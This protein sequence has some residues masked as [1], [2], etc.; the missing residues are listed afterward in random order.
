M[1]SVTI[2]ERR[3]W[4]T[5][6]LR[7]DHVGS[8]GFAALLGLAYTF[9]LVV[10]LVPVKVDA[11]HSWNGQPMIVGD[12][13][14]F[15]ASCA[16]DLLAGIHIPNDLAR[17]GRLLPILTALLASILPFSF[18]ALIYYIPTVVG[19]LIVAPLMVL[20]RVLGLTRVGFVA[21]LLAS[22]A[23]SYYNRT[24][25]GYFDTDMLTVV[26]AMSLLAVVIAAFVRRSAPCLPLI[27]LVIWLFTAA[28]PQ[29]YVL[30]LVLF[31][32][33]GV[34]GWLFDRRDDF[35]L[36]VMLYMMLGLIA[37]PYALSPV[38]AIGLY[39]TPRLVGPFSS[40]NLRWLLA[41]TSL[42]F[43]AFLVL[44]EPLILEPFRL[45]LLRSGATSGS[46]L[47]FLHVIGSVGENSAVT[48][49]TFSQRVSGPVVALAAAAA[50]YALLCWRH[51][52]LVLSLPLAAI[53]ASAF[54]GG[55]RFSIWAVPPAALGLAFV[56][57]LGVQPLR[58]A[59]LRHGAAALATGLAL[60]PHLTHVSATHEIPPFNNR[61]AR[62]LDR[63]G[64]IVSREDF[65]VAW[66]DFGYPI[67]YY[68][69]LKPVVDGGRNQ[70]DVTFPVSLVLT[71][72]D[73]R[74]AR[75]MARLTAAYSEVDRSS[76]ESIMEGEGYRDPGEFL[77]S[78]AA[79]SP[80]GDSFT[81]S[82]YPRGG[83][84]GNA[85]AGNAR[86]GGRPP[87]AGDIY[88]ILPYKMLP[89]FP[90]ISRFSNIDLT[91]GRPKPEIQY[92][93][94]RVLRTE[95]DSMVLEDG[96]RIDL[97]GGAIRHGRSSLRLKAVIRA[98]KEPATGR[99]SGKK[100][101]EYPDPA[102]S[103]TLVLMDEYRA[104][105]LV[106]D[107]ALHSQFVQLFVFE[108]YDDRYLEPVIL[109]PTMKVYRFRK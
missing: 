53:G 66:W 100:I 22:V 102:G 19:S 17:G 96:A 74:S 2:R 89:L 14:Y 43:V 48:L 11:L 20:G 92:D 12:D 40:R 97:K 1:T 38:L 84:P 45:F 107:A 37:L 36:R 90:A 35:H 98:Q 65:A 81:G 95:G 103:L 42:G 91:T 76:L 51:R 15:Y 50:G 71:T 46:T 105:L 30:L 16:R 64:A 56:I 104:A 57:M 63:L 61:E 86:T 13:G 47:R 83:R 93:L 25:A 106:D 59:A 58:L 67:R 72:T 41:A 62:V 21:A 49:T 70:G 77:R 75:K 32:V 26:L 55:A 24:M 52:V 94:T 31:L 78:L 8:M 3:L 44:G 109:D 108:E 4:D 60:Y 69:R 73:S 6:S 29:G 34:Y 87:L 68:S 9:S 85:L 5:P 54:V 82:S 33:T 39:L 23:V 79:D 80:D 7:E 88:L 18:E 101:L 27:T 28:Y 10:R 99:V